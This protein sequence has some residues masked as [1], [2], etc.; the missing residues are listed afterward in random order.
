MS[1]ATITKG[2]LAFLD[3]PSLRQDFMYN[4]GE[5]TDSKKAN[6]GKTQVPGLSH[7]VYMFGNGGERQIKF[8]L[9]H[10]GDRA[11]L[12]LRTSQH[13][14]GVEIENYLDD[15]DRQWTDDPGLDVTNWLLFYRSLLFP[16]SPWPLTTRVAGTDRT[17]WASKSP[18]KVIFNFGT[19]WQDVVCVVI[20][21]DI[22]A[23]FFTPNLEVVRADVDIVLEEA[24]DAPQFGNDIR[25]LSGSA[26]II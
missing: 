18:K 12:L 3:S 21:A 24:P 11:R 23:N 13:Q 15:T 9:H 1:R 16:E 19:F 6:W 17:F 5:I 20:Q 25:L 26:G 8:T 2:S 10:D 14:A 4:P 22:K 7:P